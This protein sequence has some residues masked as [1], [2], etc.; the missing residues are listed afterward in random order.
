MANMYD[1]NR[2]PDFYSQLPRDIDQIAQLA[3]LARL[4]EKIDQLVESVSSLT[5]TIEHV[6]GMIDSRLP[7]TIAY[8]NL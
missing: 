4:A 8:H 5:D 3:Q 2:H 1:W 6:K 7:Q